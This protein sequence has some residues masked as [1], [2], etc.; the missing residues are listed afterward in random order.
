[1]V[2]NLV[3][4]KQIQS[5]MSGHSLQPENGTKAPSLASCA[6]EVPA[7]VKVGTVIELKKPT[8]VIGFPVIKG[9]ARRRTAVFGE[10]TPI[11]VERGVVVETNTDIVMLRTE[12]ERKEVVFPLQHTTN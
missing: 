5:R 4:H 11:T 12:A 1:M 2:I 9:S 6:K 3:I 8:K 10:E 7:E